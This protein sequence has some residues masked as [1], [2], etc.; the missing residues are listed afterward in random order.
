MK[1]NKSLFI[2][3]L[4]ITLAIAFGIVFII[5]WFEILEVMREAWL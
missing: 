2:T 5:I 1:K 3:L 4:D